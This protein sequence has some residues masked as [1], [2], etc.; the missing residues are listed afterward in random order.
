MD[1]M[2]GIPGALQVVGEDADHGQ[3]R[4]KKERK[5]EEE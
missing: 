4:T 2:A 5:D 3:K 1:R